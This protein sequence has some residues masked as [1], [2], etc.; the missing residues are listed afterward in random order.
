MAISSA[1][2]NTLNFAKG[3]RRRSVCN[4]IIFIVQHKRNVQPSDS[5][6]HI[7]PPSQIASVIQEERYHR[8]RTI[9]LRACFHS[10]LKE[11]T[12]IYHCFHLSISCINVQE[13]IPS[14]TPVPRPTPPHTISI[15]QSLFSCPLCTH[16]N[17]ASVPAALISTL[18]HLFSHYSS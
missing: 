1:P 3:T 11:C 12:K 6:F 17:G 4:F 15:L 2:C 8:Y 14:C 9:A 13:H 18:S 10:W 5:G 16:S 7:P